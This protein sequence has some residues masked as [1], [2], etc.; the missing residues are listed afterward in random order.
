MFLL[1]AMWEYLITLWG[2]LGALYTKFGHKICLLLLNLT[3]IMWFIWDLRL[4]LF[5]IPKGV[6]FP[7]ILVLS[8][9]FG[10]PA[11]NWASKLAK[12]VNFGCVPFESR[13]RILKDFSNLV[14]VL[15]EDYLRPKFI[16]IYNE[17]WVVEEW[18]EL[19]CNL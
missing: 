15:L 6:V 18:V 10:F 5:D 11:V 1:W 13:F 9:I 19:F 4:T 17:M 16:Y 2:P 7:K 14:V 8:N 3:R 12:T